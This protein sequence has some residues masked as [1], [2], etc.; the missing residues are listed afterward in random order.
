M[1]I[2]VYIYIYIIYIIY[3]KCSISNMYIYIYTYTLVLLLDTYTFVHLYYRWWY[4]CAWSIQSQAWASGWALP[5][6]P[7]HLGQ[8]SDSTRTGGKSGGIP[9]GNP[10]KMVDVWIINWKNWWIRWEL[11]SGFIKRLENPLSMVG[12]TGKSPMNGLFSIA[13]F[14]YRRV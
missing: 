1:Y 6:R 4:T 14:D 10:G 9:G 3:N 7:W 8:I 5:W 11:P 2:R 12:F 13:M